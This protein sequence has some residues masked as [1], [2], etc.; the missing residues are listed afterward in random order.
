MCDKHKAYYLE[1]ARLL[2]LKR[3][4]LQ[5]PI[6]PEA[7]LAYLSSPLHWGNEYSKK[8]ESRFAILDNMLQ[9]NP[10]LLESL[11]G[12]LE[13]ELN[14]SYIFSDMERL[15]ILEEVVKKVM[16][17]QP[18]KLVY[19]YQS[20]AKLSLKVK[21]YERV[22]EICR[23]FKDSDNFELSLENL[24]VHVYVY[25]LVETGNYEEAA[26]YLDSLMCDPTSNLD[27]LAQA[28][29]GLGQPDEAASI[30]ARMTKETSRRNAQAPRAKAPLPPNLA[31]KLGQLFV[32]ERTVISKRFGFNGAPMSYKEI[33]T[34]PPFL[35]GLK[36]DATF[37][38]HIVEEAMRK[39]EMDHDSLINI[40]YPGFVFDEHAPSSLEKAIAKSQEKI[41]DYKKRFAIKS[42]VK[43]ALNGEDWRT[44]RAGLIKHLELNPE[45]IELEI[46]K[47]STSNE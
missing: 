17:Y 42:I 36:E 24:P 5:N 7:V 31:E 12:N 47:S 8:E 25:A 21:N 46:R 28:Y 39:L 30:K 9:K 22:L 32:L 34:E 43:G 11:A 19:A 1:Q 6:N 33:A 4:Y 15:E 40:Y 27:Y 18:S 29:E 23:L 16:R 2:E 3:E 38:K 35:D 44:T 45:E 13:I 14:N 37:A 41:P 26:P 20:L 10:D